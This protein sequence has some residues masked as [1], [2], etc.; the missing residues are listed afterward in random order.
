M[1]EFHVK[2]NLKNQHHPHRFMIHVISVF[3]MKFNVEFTCQAVNFSIIYRL[4]EM[5]KENLE[6]PLAHA[7]VQ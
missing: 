6:S 1:S 5:P 7:C 3:R 4:S 2:F